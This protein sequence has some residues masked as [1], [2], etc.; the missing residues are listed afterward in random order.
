MV[1]Y[2]LL[3]GTQKAQISLVLFI[4]IF[5]IF[6]P[7][8]AVLAADRLFAKTTRVDGVVLDKQYIKPAEKSAIMLSGEELE[9][10]LTHWQDT[11]RLPRETVSIVYM[12]A[13]AYNSLPNQTDGSPYKTAIGSLTRHGVIASNYFPIG[14]RIRIPDHYGDQEFRVEDRMNPRYDK[15]LDIWMEHKADAKQFGRRYIKVEVV[16]WGLGRGVE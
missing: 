5:E 6:L 8:N 2:A 14:T 10:S 15:T 11:Q 4:F 3:Y 7:T 12:N 13:S 1:Q 16:Q 9:D